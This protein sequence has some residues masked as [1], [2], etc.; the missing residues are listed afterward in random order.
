MPEM[1]TLPLFDGV[2]VPIDAATKKLA[3]FGE[4]GAGKTY[5]SMK[6]AELFWHAGVQFVAFDP[7]GVWPGLRTNADGSPGIPIAVFGG[8]NG[9]IPIGPSHGGIVAETIVNAGISAVIDVSQF[10]T[11]SAKAHFASDFA[12]RFFFLKKSAPSAVHVFLEEAQEFV[13]ESPYGGPQSKETLM[14]NRFLRIWK[15]GR[16]FGIGGSLIS[17]RPQEISKKALNLSNCILAFRMT[18]PHERD[19]M[20][21]WFK[22]HGA[23]VDL[24]KIATGVPYVWSAHWLQVSDTFRVLPKKT[25]DLSATPEV[26]VESAPRTLASVDVEALRQAMAVPDDAGKEADTAALRARIR[27][28]EAEARAPRIDPLIVKAAGE[29]DE[30]K[31]RAEDAETKLARIMALCKTDAV[32]VTTVKP[33]RPSSAPS[34]VRNADLPAAKPK[35]QAGNGKESAPKMR[36][37]AA[38]AFWAPHFPKGVPRLFVAFTA[39]YKPGTG[40]FNNIL[41]NLRTDGLVDYPGSGTVAVTPAGAALVSVKCVKREEAYKALLGSIQAKLTGPQWRVFS[42]L[43]QSYPEAVHMTRNVLATEAGYTAGTGNFNNLCGQLRSLGLVDYPV[44]GSIAAE[45][46]LFP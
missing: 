41:G 44:S 24:P 5:G 30:W 20:G 27:A 28:L 4:N 38:V 34:P 9:D 6:L 3:W 43:L 19:Y 23:E 46:V 7:V 18:G 8:L 12:E 13:P 10:E 31:R 2:A 39:Q 1:K 32:A 37:L 35:E 25:F 40:N 22:G 11:D 45:R 21:K 17:Q 33:D 15:I 26:G 36:V 29:R 42:P 16:N 14:T